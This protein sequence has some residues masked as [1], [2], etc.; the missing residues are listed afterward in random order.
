M[1]HLM[2][3]EYESKWSKANGEG[4]A[5]GHIGEYPEGWDGEIADGPKYDEAVGKRNR[6]GWRG[7]SVRQ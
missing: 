4:A 6:A 2:V 1:P 3:R 5:S 7:G